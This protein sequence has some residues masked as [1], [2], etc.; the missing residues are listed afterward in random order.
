MKKYLVYILIRTMNVKKIAEK[1]SLPNSSTQSKIKRF[2]TKKI[3]PI[4]L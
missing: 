1:C 4:I 2:Q 3:A